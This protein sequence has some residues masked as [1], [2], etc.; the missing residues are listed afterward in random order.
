SEAGFLIRVRPSGAP[1]Y[2]V[3]H[4]L[5]QETIYNATLRKRRQ[6]LHRRLFAAVSRN[7]KLAGWLGTAEV[8]EH[9]E[10]AGLLEDAIAQF[11]I[12]GTESSSRSA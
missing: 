10:R 6:A 2:G 7:R 9:A 4:A 12:A 1:V 11:V 5:I 3:R 8:A